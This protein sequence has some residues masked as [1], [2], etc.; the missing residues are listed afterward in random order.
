MISDSER[1][2][3][4]QAILARM[5]PEPPRGSEK[6]PDDFPE[7]LKRKLLGLQGL[8][9]ELPS[10]DRLQQISILR[11]AY[12]EDWYRNI[13]RWVTTQR[14]Q[15]HARRRLRFVPQLIK[16]IIEAARPKFI[17]RPPKPRPRGRPR[18]PRPRGR[19]RKLVKKP[20]GRPR[21]S[22]KPR[23]WYAVELANTP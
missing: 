4:I 3:R 13:P 14:Y 7:S 23:G 10:K 15:R 11:E 9:T 17:G 16:Q 1:L 21:K 20:V 8:I 5:P 2:E 12:L 18:K 22:H 19:P 6:L